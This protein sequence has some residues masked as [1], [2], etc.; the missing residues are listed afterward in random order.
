[1]DDDLDTYDTDEPYTEK[2][3]AEKPYADTPYTDETEDYP[4]GADDN[5][6][7]EYR[8]EP[9]MIYSARS[10]VTPSQR[11]IDAVIQPSQETS[12]SLASSLNTPVAASVTE[13]HEPVLDNPDMVFPTEVS[14][15]TGF[16]STDNP[17]LGNPMPE[18]P[19]LLIT[20]ESR[21]K[22]S[23]TELSMTNELRTEGE[24]TD[25]HCLHLS[26][27]PI[28]QEPAPRMMRFHMADRMDGMDREPEEPYR[29]LIQD[30]IEYG[31]L[32]ERYGQERIDPIV[33]I[34]SDAVLSTKPII[35]IAGQ[36]MP[37]AAVKSRFLKLNSE[38]IEYVLD[39]LSAN[40]TQ[41]RNIKAYMLTAL[42][43]APATMDSY[44]A[45]KV[46]YD[47]YARRKTAV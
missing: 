23:T 10:S 37:Q 8:P 43:N 38:H 21:T 20:K 42:Y 2:P 22:G 14:P 16:P 27:N 19:A 30:N 15:S 44:Y 35:R 41:V 45:A 26:I 12:Y 5:H 17:R 18:N 1:V 32:S 29:G 47:L 46:S 31:E 3:Y 39:C 7:P 4:L 33:D 25:L 9:L 13:A 36:D 40:T 24:N 11:P 28:N 34:I 6:T